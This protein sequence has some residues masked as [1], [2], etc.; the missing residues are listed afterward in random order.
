MKS[1]IFLLAIFG[2]RIYFS[3][4][5]IFGYSYNGIESGNISYWA[6]LIMLLSLSIFFHAKTKIEKGTVSKKEI[7][8]SYI[9]L[10]FIFYAFA[11]IEISGYKGANSFFNI[12]YFVI[13]SIPALLSGNYFSERKN[14]INYLNK[15]LEIIMI[16]FT[17]GSFFSTFLTLFS[18]QV[19]EGFGG[20]TY[21]E[22][23]Y[24]SAFSFGINLHYL[25]YG[26]KYERYSFF[27]K[28]LYKLIQIIMLLIQLLSLTVGGG[29]GAFVLF[30][31]YILATIVTLLK[32]NEF[33][34]IMK[35]TSVMVLFI[36]G[37]M[38]FFKF[39][40]IDEGVIIKGIKRMSGFIATNGI[41]WSKTSGR[42]IVYKELLSLI[43]NN[44]IF[45]IGI[46]NY[47]LPH[48]LFLEVL[49][50]TGIIGLIFFII[51]VFL[52]LKKF[53]RLLN[54]QPESHIILII[55]LFP[56]IML[57]FSSSMFRNPEFSFV[58]SY[59]YFSRIKYKSNIEMK[60]LK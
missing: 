17:L 29:R 43:K 23:A 27:K 6:Y 34:K 25:I 36:L 39:S 30:W 5:A 57:M 22:A 38:V 12:Y 56:L 51:L 40:K 59:V 37:T 9:C 2:Q 33:K 15:N 60:K 11:S 20:G 26:D 47:P 53:N 49:V 14:G 42:D 19:F 35:F 31:V 28:R 45:G 54:V 1:L 7:I 50:A 58:I 4:L 10:L 52:F 3:I 18:N 24:I 55:F 48:N 32:G 21:Q 46:F 8:L 41:D 16:V 44:Y 13:F